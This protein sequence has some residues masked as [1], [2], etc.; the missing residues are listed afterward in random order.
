MAGH[1]SPKP[2]K[3][4]ETIEVSGEHIAL[5]IILMIL[6]FGISMAALYFG[7]KGLLTRQSGWTRIE[8]DSGNPAQASSDIDFEYCLSSNATAEN[9]LLTLLYTDATLRAWQVYHPTEAFAGIGNLRNVNA[10]PNTEVTVEPELY[11]AFELIQAQNSRVLFLA[12][13]YAQYDA[14]YRSLDDDEAAIY[15]PACS[16]EAAVYVAEVM[17]F[18]SDP[19]AISL[20]LLGEN[21][22]RLNVREDYLRYAEDYEIEAFLDFC[23]LKNAFILD[24]LAEKIR[25]EGFTRGYIVSREGFA[26]YLDKA[27]TAD[28]TLRLTNWTETGIAAPA[29][30]RIREGMSLACLHSYSLNDTTA[31]YFYLYADG[32][33]VTPYLDPATGEIRAAISDLTLLSRTASCAELALS[34][35]SVLTAET[36]DAADLTALQASDIAVIWCEGKTLCHTALPAELTVND[37]SYT[38]KTIP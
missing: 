23:W 1:F 6:L 28:Y 37:A 11:R 26:R 20:D 19:A 36:W 25:S 12:P 34:A 16:E 2:L 31:D 13:V 10:A 3:P 32:R 8:A 21:R 9:K 24:D 27:S 30:L 18:V 29:E 4:R 35:L 17:G 15:D 7:V 38:E 5:R 14:V 33:S 22:V